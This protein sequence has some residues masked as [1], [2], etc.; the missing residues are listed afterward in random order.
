[1]LCYSACMPAARQGSAAWQFTVQGEG[2]RSKE[3]V[4]L[5]KVKAMPKKEKPLCKMKKSEIEERLDELRKVVCAPR[6]ICSQC[7]RVAAH[8]RYLC[9]PEK[10]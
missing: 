6:F 5:W 7:A 10:L 9:H 1:M 3:I 2:H 8:E 4:I